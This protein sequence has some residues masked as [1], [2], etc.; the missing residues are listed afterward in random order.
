[1]TPRGG[2]GFARKPGFLNKHVLDHLVNKDTTKHFYV[3]SAY[4]V[5]HA[6]PLQIHQPRLGPNSSPVGQLEKVMVH[7]RLADPSV[8]HHLCDTAS[9]ATK[10]DEQGVASHSL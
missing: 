9:R 10:L 7:T 4:D 3:Q 6:T 2:L 1:M 5:D 8:H